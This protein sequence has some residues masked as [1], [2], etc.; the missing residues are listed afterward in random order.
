MREIKFR[1]REVHI[2]SCGNQWLDWETRNCCNCKKSINQKEAVEAPFLC[3]IEQALNI[4]SIDG[5]VPEDI[6]KR[7]GYDPEADTWAW[8]CPEIEYTDEWKRERFEEEHQGR[9][10][11]NNWPEIA[12]ESGLPCGIVACPKCGKAVAG[13]LAPD[14]TCVC[15]YKMFTKNEHV[16][17]VNGEESNV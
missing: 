9:L 10:F 8:A 15:G 2:F 17:N 4:A 14:L 6:A 3:D 1:V 13:Y 12:Q 11:A 16:Q 5:M 7:A